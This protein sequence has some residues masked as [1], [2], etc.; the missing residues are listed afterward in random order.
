MP[1]GLKRMPGS[2]LSALRH[3]SGAT[4]ALRGGGE[5]QKP[6]CREEPGSEGSGSLVPQVRARFWR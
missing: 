5:T 6:N 1:W 4:I 2:A 3:F